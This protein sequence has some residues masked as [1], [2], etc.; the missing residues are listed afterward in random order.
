MVRVRGLVKTYTELCGDSMVAVNDVTMDIIENEITVLLGHNGAG[1]T[2]LMSVICGIFPA[3]KG[4]VTVD[5]ETSVGAY[6]NK[7]GYCS[8]HNIIFPY[9]TCEEHLL[10]FGTVRFQFVGF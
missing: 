4:T 1:K 10:F 6:R 7:I 9:L 5:G 2:T 3:T 8:Q